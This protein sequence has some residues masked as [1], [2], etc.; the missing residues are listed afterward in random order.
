MLGLCLVL[1]NGLFSS[2]LLGIIKVNYY[3][4]I[5]NYLSY[6]LKNY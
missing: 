4:N 5:E 6:V 1:E 3:I 2:F